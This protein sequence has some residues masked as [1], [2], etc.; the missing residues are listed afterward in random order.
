MTEGERISSE[1]FN[2]FHETLAAAHAQQNE[3][4]LALGAFTPRL[5]MRSFSMAMAG[6]DPHH[7]ARFD[8]DVEAYRYRFIQQLNELHATKIH[9]ENDRSERVNRAEW[10]PLRG[11]RPGAPQHTVGAGA[12]GRTPDRVGRLGRARGA[13]RVTTEHRVMNQMETRERSPHWR[14]FVQLEFRSF[15]RRR[16]AWVAALGL[17]GAG[18]MAIAHGASRVS[19]ERG[20]VAAR[21]AELNEQ[22]GYLREVRRADDDLGLFLYYLAMP[23]AQRPGAWAPLAT[24][25]R[26]VHPASRQLRFLGL[27]PQLYDSE[28][29][30]P[31]LEQAGH[32]DL[33]H[34][35]RWGRACLERFTSRISWIPGG[36]HPCG[37]TAP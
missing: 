11:V 17:L 5:A 12:C 19:G 26:G 2:A 34:Y 27:V 13:R 23:V 9:W 7:I 28:L 24:G 3:L 18:L 21:E 35:Q 29:G 20:A 10:G 15:W 6:T 25:L 33:A 14:R 31:M 30:N 1:E 36:M 4:A 32:F 22:A 37:T 8:A 16:L